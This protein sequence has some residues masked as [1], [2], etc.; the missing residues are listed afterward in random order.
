[1]TETSVDVLGFKVAPITLADAVGRVLELALQPHTEASL[2]VTLNPEIVVRAGQDPDLRK[3]LTRAELTVADGVGVVWAARY[4]GAAL[5]ERV[6]GVDLVTSVLERGGASL[7]VFFLGSKPGVAQR[8]AAHAH[9][10]YGT[11]VAGWHHGYFD[12]QTEA[13]A[14]VTTVRESGAALLL[15]GLGEDQELFL[16]RYRETHGIPV[17]IGVGGTLDV[18]AGAVRRSPA[19]TRRLGVEWVWRVGGD[20]RRWGRFPRLLRFAFLVLRRGRRVRG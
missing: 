10:R 19:W 5:P 16:D 8:A 9:G 17:A 1:M 3:A 12:G 4:S 7:S 2:V 18:L 14:I 15:A 20:P 11:V 6:P 13:E